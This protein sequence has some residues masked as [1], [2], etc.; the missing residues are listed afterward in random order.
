MVESLNRC[1]LPGVGVLNRAP[2][3]GEY[4]AAVLELEKKAKRAG[5]WAKVPVED[6]MEWRRWTALI[7]M[8]IQREFR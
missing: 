6:F 2:T 7:R 4:M 3:L 5:G 1:S 8:K